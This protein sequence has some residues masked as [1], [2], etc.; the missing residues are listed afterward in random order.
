MLQLDARLTAAAYCAPPSAG[1]ASIAIELIARAEKAPVDIFVSPEQ[2]APP[3]LYCRTGLSLDHEQLMSLADIGIRDF[4]VRHGDVR[5]LGEYL[6]EAYLNGRRTVTVA[7]QFSAMQVVVSAEI[8]HAVRLLDCSKF[9]CLAATVGRDIAA[10]ISSR[11]VLPYEIFSVAR[12]DFSTFVHVTNV[13]SYSVLLAKRLGINDIRQLELLASAA[14]LHDLGKRHIPAKILNKSGRLTTT[15]RELVEMH[16]TRG[17]I[18]LCSRPDLTFE[19]LMVVYQHHERIDG[20]GYP[21]GIT[22]KHISP[23]A[24]LIAV[25]D[26]FDALTGERPYRE[27]I[28]PQQAI[29]YLLRNAGTHFDAEIVQCWEAAFRE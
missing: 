8:E 19:Q 27:P 22:G 25:V 7:E 2:A 28:S 21:V 4:Y 24:K 14:M 20:T 11:N 9:V 18:E 15:E 29:G 17:Y 12:H 10:F 6:R 23:W 16:P 5:R 1:Y 13:A 26:V 3:K